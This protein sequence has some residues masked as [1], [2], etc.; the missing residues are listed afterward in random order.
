MIQLP[1]SHHAT[2]CGIGS[3]RGCVHLSISTPQLDR[4]WPRARLAPSRVRLAPKVRYLDSPQ[5]HLPCNYS[6]QAAVCT[7]FELRNT[8]GKAPEKHFPTL[9]T[10]SEPC[11]R[12]W[13]WL[14]TSLRPFGSST[15]F[16]GSSR[17]AAHKMHTKLRTHWATVHTPNCTHTCA[18]DV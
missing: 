17:K 8:L 4:V 18:W 3:Y 9:T 10:P 15:A 14:D 16:F 11:P 2:S 13:E 1:T 7:Q 12:L 6:C 5:N